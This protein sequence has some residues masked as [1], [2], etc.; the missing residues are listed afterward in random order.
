MSKRLVVNFPVLG[1]KHGK[2]MKAIVGV[3]AG[4]GD[5]EVSVFEKESKLEVSVLNEKVV[6]GKGILQKW[7]MFLA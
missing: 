7:L 6:L 4:F 1:K 2:L 5:D 3:V